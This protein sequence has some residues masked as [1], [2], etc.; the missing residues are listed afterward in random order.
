MRFKSGDKVIVI[1]DKHK[2]KIGNIKSVMPKIR[3]VTVDE[4]NLV[5]KN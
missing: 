5:K 3:K 1:I 4:V 2:G